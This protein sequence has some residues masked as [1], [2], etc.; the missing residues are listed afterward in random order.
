MR[1]KI[2][3]KTLLLLCCLTVFLPC[4]VHAGRVNV[5]GFSGPV[6]P[7][8]STVP[9]VATP[10]VNIPG[11]Y[12]SSVTPPASTQLPV[13]RDPAGAIPGIKGVET[14]SSQNQLIIHQDQP[15]A[16]IDWESFN[17]GA[18]AWTIFDQQGNA[19][20]SAL[21]RIWDRNPSLIF[22]RLTADGKIYLINQNGILFGAGSQV[23]VNSLVASALNI[24]SDN[25]IN[26]V[27]QFRY[28]DY[29]ADPLNP[30]NS[31]AAVS[32]LGEIN[33]ANGGS[34]FLIGPRVENIGSIN[35]PMGQIGLA[36]GTVIDLLT[37][38]IDIS[39]DATTYTRT[40]L[41]VDVQDG[42][43]EAVNREGGQLVANEGVAG[44]YGGTVTQDGL[45]RS[46]TAVSQHGQIELIASDRISTGSNSLIE[47]PIS[48]SSDTA[49]NSF[50]FSGGV[51]LMHGNFEN[52]DYASANPP[53]VIELKGA[54]NAPSGTV[55]L[56][57]NDR[58]FL[59]TGSSISVGGAWS[60]ET[61]TVALVES[62]L[63]SVELRD[64]Y[65]Q[66]DGLLLGETI[67]T[68]LLTGSSI[69]DISDSILNEQKTALERAVTGGDIYITGGSSG[70]I[71]VKQGATLDFSGGGVSYSGG[72]LDSTRLLSGTK[73]YDISDA[74]LN[75]RYDSIIGQYTKTYARYGVQESYSG[76]YYGGAAPLKTTHL[77]AFT[78]G[79]DAG[80]LQLAA[81]MVVL[82]GNLN[83]AVTRGLFQNTWTTYDPSSDS[84]WTL[85]MLQGLEIPRAGNLIIGKV[86]TETNIGTQDT[87]VKEITVSADS[88]PLDAG[89]GS[90]PTQFQLTNQQT[91]IAADIVN[92]AGL[93]SLSLY[94]NTKIT[95]DSDA[96]IQLSAGG[97]FTAYARRI[98]NAGEISVPSGT[99][100]MTVA[101]Y[102]LPDE[103]LTDEIFL[104]SG[105][106]LDVS[107]ERIDNSLA[108]KSADGV[109]AY[110][111]IG[112]GT[113]NLLD[114]TDKGQGVFIQTGAIV[115]VSG[116]YTIYQNGNVTGGN[117]GSLNIQGSNIMLNGELRGYALADPDGQISGG[118]VTL[119]ATNITVDNTVPSWPADF[120]AADGVP[121]GMNGTFIL[122]ANR[123]DYTG[124]TQITLNSVGDIVIQPN[125]TVKTS[126]VRL[127]DP[128]AALRTGTAPSTEGDILTG[129]PDLIR[130]NDSL[131]FMAGKSSF[132]ANAGQVFAGS[133]KD[134]TGNMID[135]IKYSEKIIVS[136]GSVVSS[137]P[138][139]AISLSAPALID[140]AG[141]LE[142][143]AG[144]VS[145]KT[146]G[147]ATGD[148]GDLL[149]G[150]GGRIIANGYNRPDAAAII[151]GT[152][153]NYSPMAGGAVS[154]SAKNDLVL[155]GGSFIDVS[156]S[157]SVQNRLKSGSGKTVIYT[158]ASDPGSLSLTFSGSL[159]WNGDVKAQ[160]RMTGVSGG[161]LTVSNTGN[162]L[163]IRAGD[164]QKYLGAGF[165]DLT[166]KSTDVLRLSGDM[167]MTAGRK[168]TLDAPE[169]SGAGGNDVTLRSPWIELANTSG[170]LP[171]GKPSEG[172]GHLFLTSTGWIDLDGSINISGFQDVCLEAARDIRLTDSYYDKS[173]SNIWEG[174]LSTA[175]DLTMKADRIYPMTLSTYEIYADGKATILPADN[176]FG[177][178]IYSAG[179]N[180]TIGA[181]GGIE[182]QGVLAAPMGT[183]N[184]QNYTE[185]PGSS[186]GGRIYLAEGSVVTTQGDAT[187]KYGDLDVNG[188]WTIQ[189][190]DNTVVSVDGV[191]LKSVT[192][193]AVGGD[194]I[195][196][197]NAEI[198]TSGG[199]S[200]F[201]YNFQPGVEGSVDPLAISG[202]YVVLSDRSVQLPGEAVYLTG[203]G[204]L[205]AG[206]Y[207]LL[208]MEYAF[209][210]GA[211]VIEL[212]S[213]TGVMPSRG[214]MSKDGYPISVGYKTV[215]NT[216]IQGTEPLVYSVRT[217]SDV[218]KEG[219]YDTQTFSAGDAGDLKISGQTTIIDGVL[220]AAALE[221]F[222][223]GLIA[224]SGKDIYV[225]ESS[226]PLPEGF[227][228]SSPV[229]GELEGTLN[230]N[231][232][233]LSGQGF[234]EIDLGDETVTDT[235]T[236][237][238][239][240]VLEAPVISLTANKM[241]TIETGAQLNAL[242]ETGIGEI[243]LNSP[244]GPPKSRQGH[245]C[246]HRMFSISTSGARRSRETC[247]WTTAR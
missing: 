92:T 105:S 107:G 200:V 163:D 212:Q 214:T 123:F 31:L 171:Q 56:N 205:A 4:V 25:F 226:A 76:I 79:G 148:V 41:I 104:A 121:S 119:S 48:Y 233:S 187:V 134:A 155:A 118:S 94:A 199:G 96:H 19:N 1:T 97:N 147:G 188:S 50:A 46:V 241:I 202:R 122:A 82:D 235:I 83:G 170:Y 64:A 29:V 62:Q 43:G 209:L 90:D 45:I 146:T 138:E 77:N 186:T 234:R 182:I 217:A 36:A 71:I 5:P 22:G 151:A 63:N 103:E 110:G 89:F 176:P 27:L 12:G 65:G 54:V 40:A 47:S 230:V 72:V 231:A 39:E 194:V 70:D 160:A 60:N 244:G 167:D 112:G 21:N 37:P 26:N 164:I 145:L 133:Y 178:T 9:Q 114:K 87:A 88:S 125:T 236:I 156:G 85:S 204:G 180:L 149:I 169:I 224:L 228:F 111:Q 11:F 142:S 192:I 190:K 38:S 140:M 69:G 124:F 166:L 91:V 7:M 35:A 100:T 75:I 207:S 126:L 132:T 93:G 86:P 158:D 159:T 113:I 216:F 117:A 177:G 20:W 150:D 152:V 229:P 222:P 162:L 127:N 210:P 61:A 18:D 120:S 10:S 34:V 2:F 137:A 106:R 73:I 144:T 141:T 129:Q 14:D 109:I 227:G 196:R 181:L 208:P 81:G 68:N 201:T 161:T 28:E 183:I 179:G 101:D 52:P 185:D 243:D 95:T 80:T 102:I 203:G 16:I 136:A 218:L 17:I 44:M 24:T 42:F 221:G 213:G 220:K 98:E 238:G 32:N 197:D 13:L 191:P 66:K 247:R 174:K 157:A 237:T 108:G 143:L 189:A 239:G 33:A 215:A 115:D 223:G 154:L 198:N 139:G 175:G 53:S 99:I 130:L 246:T 232:A 116:G 49:D 245:C 51:V 242:A 58:V 3:R 153:V 67:T 240:S 172:D 57:A 23:N 128:T 8:V 6:I 59:E 55:T 15:Q 131:A 84:A 195:V 184:L 219:H 165:D 135:N 206:T 30:L 193:N 211:Y 74:P 78:T 173:V 168:L 225:R